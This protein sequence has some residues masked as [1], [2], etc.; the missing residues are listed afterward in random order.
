MS[1]EFS[2]V[3]RKDVE[4]LAPRLMQAAQNAA[5]I[6]EVKHGRF[7]RERTRGGGGVGTSGLAGPL[8]SG[9]ELSATADSVHPPS[10]ACRFSRR[11]A[12]AATAKI[13]ARVTAMCAGQ[14]GHV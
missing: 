5:A 8:S 11:P 7:T 4:T 10:G 12:S 13:A 6:A 3:T 2:A 9:L 14:S 1:E